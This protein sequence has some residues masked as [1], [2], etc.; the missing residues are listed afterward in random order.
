MKSYGV[1]IKMKPLQQYFHIVLF[2]WYVVVTFESVDEILW[3]DHSNETSSVVL[4]HGTICFV[5]SS[6]F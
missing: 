2:F 6:N 3:C 1:I 4:S 5:C